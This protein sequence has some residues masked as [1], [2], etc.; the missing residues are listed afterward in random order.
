MNTASR[1]VMTE[2]QQLEKDSVQIETGPGKG[3]LEG[4]VPYRQVIGEYAE[5]EAQAA[6]SA[7]LTREQK[8]WVDEYF[9]RLT[10]E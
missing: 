4:S 9:R 10:E 2:Q 7:H 5:T 6:E 8:E 1:D 3:S